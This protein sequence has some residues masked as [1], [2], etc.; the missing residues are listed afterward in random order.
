MDIASEIK[1]KEESILWVKRNRK[2]I[3]DKF[4][5]LEDYPASNRPFSFFM[6]GSP[7]AGKTEFSISFIKNLERLDKKFKIVRIDAD[8]I[9]NILPLYNHKNSSIVQPAYQNFCKL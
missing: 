8:E 7:G 5:N 1:V 6:A 3:C 4:A 9:R 2:L